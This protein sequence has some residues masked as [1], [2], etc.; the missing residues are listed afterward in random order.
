[1]ATLNGPDCHTAKRSCLFSRLI[2]AAGTS[3]S[4]AFE[5]GDTPQEVWGG[6]TAEEVES[7]FG[8][9]GLSAVGTNAEKPER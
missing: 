4:G 2:V 8:I 3:K 6:L 5:V 7:A 1:M 9:A